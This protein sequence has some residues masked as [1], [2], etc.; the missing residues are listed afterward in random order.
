M[1]RLYDKGKEFIKHSERL[2]DR[3]ELPA[4]K[5][6]E[7]KA[8]AEALAK[9]LEKN[10]RR[11]AA[12]KAARE[13]PERRLAELKARE[14]VK[15]DGARERAGLHQ[16][17]AE[18]S[19]QAAAR[20][21]E[22]AHARLGTQRAQQ[23]TIRLRRDAAVDVEIARQGTLRTEAQTHIDKVT[24]DTL[25]LERTTQAQKNAQIEIIEANA[26][27][28]PPGNKIQLDAKGRVVG[29]TGDAATEIAKAK[30]IA[31]PDGMA[32]KWIKR[33]AGALLGFVVLP[34]VAIKA[35]PD[36]W[37][38]EYLHSAGGMLSG[39]LATGSNKAAGDSVLTGGNNAL[40]EQALGANGSGAPRHQSG[41]TSQRST[42]I[43]DLSA[44]FQQSATSLGLN[45]AQGK[46]LVDIGVSAANTGF[47]KADFTLNSQQYST[48]ANVFKQ[49]TLSGAEKCKFPQ[50]TQEQLIKLTDGVIETWKPTL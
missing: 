49:A 35:V 26:R 1:G 19:A 14:Q 22:A 30:M 50:N 20:Q 5:A 23:D 9:E 36:S 12:E 2:K 47:D 39:R 38:P 45:A 31:K 41:L 16:G 21:A 18:A 11:E 27:H 6:A 13:A 48:W 4:R 46:C 10:A 32:M 25:A 8:A 17:A 7:E 15:T 42:A 3:I 34:L 37:L 28:A 24:A 29:A 40:I 33:G 43:A 44:F